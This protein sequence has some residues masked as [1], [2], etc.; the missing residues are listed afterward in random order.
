M[1][2]I[3]TNQIIKKPNF[4]LL[5][6]I[7]IVLVEPQGSMNVGSTCRAMKNFGISRLYLVR[8]GCQI[9]VDAVKMALNAKDILDNAIIVNDIADA[10]KGCS[11]VLGTGNRVGEYHKPNYT[12]KEALELIKNS[13]FDGD[14]AILF[15]REEWGLTK[16]DLAYAQGCVKINTSPNFSSLNL[17][18]AVIIF[19]YEIYQLIESLETNIENKSYEDQLPTV[20]ELD[21]LYNHMFK[22]LVFCEF[23]PKTNPDGLF[24]I[25]RAFFSRARPTR[26]EINVFMGVFSNI[27]GFF[28]KYIFNKPGKR[29]SVEEAENLRK[30]IIN[31]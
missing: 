25:I 15:G 24:Q 6:K 18:Q 28:C 9:D 7:R 4:D 22:I 17:S 14:V 11:L 12:V 8:P 3:N 30:G 19:A 20:E 29:L 5:N 27:W 16:E 2:K 21:K 23:L 26:R 31:K 13:I 10:I 1:V